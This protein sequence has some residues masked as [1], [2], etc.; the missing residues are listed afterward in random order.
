MTRHFS[1]LVLAVLAT[2]CSTIL[3]D[4]P[5][6]TASDS[7]LDPGT[8]EASEDTRDCLRHTGGTQPVDTGTTSRD[9]LFLS[10]ELF[11]CA[12]DVVVVSEDD[13][14]E[15]VAAA[16]L[17]AALGAPLL[18]PDDRLAAEIGRLHPSRIHVIGQ[19]DLNAPADSE[20]LFR[21]ITESVR[22]SSEALGTSEEIRLP[23]VPDASTIIE[24]VGAISDADRV[25]FPQ[26]SPTGTAE[27]NPI[28]NEAELVKGLAIANDA[29]SIWMVDASDP[30]AVLLA[31]G[32]GQTVAARTVAID[33]NDVLGYPEVGVA[34]QGEK[35]IRFIGGAPDANEW[36]ISVLTNGRQVPGGGFVILP[37]EQRRYV[38]FY[39]HPDTSALGVLGEQDGEATIERMQP[40]LTAYE[41]DGAQVV[42]AFEIIAT[43]ASAGA[44]DDGNYSYEWPDEAFGDLL[45]TAERHDAYVLLDL[46]PGRTDFL[47][48]AKIY[49]N[50][51]MR[52]NVG[53]ALDPEWRL[54][55][56]Q[57]HLQQTGTVD[58]AEINTVIEWLGDLVRD[59]GLPQKILLL[60]MFRPDMITNR[61][62]LVERQELQIVI[63]MD[64][65]GT[66]QQKD[67]TWGRLRNGFEDA[68]WAWG[69]KNFFDEDEPGP[70]TPESTMSKEPTPVYVSYQ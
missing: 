55:P 16:Q 20:V 34:L 33:G 8:T 10:G 68:F 18:F 70:P 54:G 52:P 57:V 7:S 32:T 14:N 23:T 22:L 42:P 19:L 2:A 45:E 36:E 53:L 25:V 60:H 69:W 67:A 59:N 41:G 21:S 40:F 49:Q 27:T 64:G 58:A 44:G 39:G 1:T 17:A 46:Q 56:D 35:T 28:I 5:V 13:I 9:A 24:T 43:V 37:E 62:D 26:T 29:S 61:E 12:V 63:Q 15:V 30:V 65:D 31:A 51:L 66:E 50:L 4:T 11:V 6:D 47:T 38:A 48:Q 3:G